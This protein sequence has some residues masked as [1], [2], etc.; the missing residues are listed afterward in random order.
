MKKLYYFSKQNLQFIEIRNYKSKLAI[1]FS[2]AVII[3]SAMMAAGYYF[4]SQAV[5]AENNIVN[6]KSENR[7]LRDKISQIASEYKSLNEEL[8]NLKVSNNDLRVAVNLPLLSDEERMLGTGGGSF[9][10]KLDF[11]KDDPDNLELKEALSFV[12]EIARKVEFE[13]DQYNEIT[14]K[15][16]SNKK[17]FGSIPAIKPCNGTLT[18]HGFG[19][20][21]H[22]ILKVRKMHDGIDI[23]TDR[24][25]PVYAPGNGTVVFV[26]YRGGYGLAV[27]IN[28]GFGYNTLYAHLSKTLVKE[29]QK[30]ERGSLIAKT[31]NSGLSSGPHLHYEVH[32]NGIKQDP[33]RF[34]FDDMNFFELTSKN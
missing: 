27:E 30:V 12:D 17:L 23:I 2:V 6:L 3:F 10:N 25:T 20:R 19:L 32:H 11:L 28:H 31:G 16:E 21:Y 8:E 1:Y 9:D 22:P 33:E 5:D 29:G 15:L 24:G 18:V 7:L 26:G 4:I 13:K 14:K 34:F